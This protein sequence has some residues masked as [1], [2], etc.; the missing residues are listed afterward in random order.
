MN[1]SSTSYVKMPDGTLICWGAVSISNGQSQGTAQFPVEFI[2]KD[3]LAITA[4]PVST[5]ATCNIYYGQTTKS[6]VTVSRSGTSGDNSF[7]YIAIG[8]WK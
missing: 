7:Y 4:T 1:D 6:Q 5:S 3:S 2:S 8:R